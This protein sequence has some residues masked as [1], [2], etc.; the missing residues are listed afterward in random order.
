LKLRVKLTR[1]L[2]SESSYP[3]ADVGGLNLS[4]LIVV[5]LFFANAE[6][7]LISA[8]KATALTP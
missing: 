3:T 8:S 1:E 5:N 6:A 7:S 4:L 2:Y